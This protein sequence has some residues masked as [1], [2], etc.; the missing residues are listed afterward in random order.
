MAQINQI[1]EFNRNTLSSVGS[2][3]KKSDWNTPPTLFN[4]GL[5]E[6]VFHLID[7]KISND[8]TECDLL[9]YFMSYFQKLNT[10]VNYL[11]IGVSVGKTFYQICKF[12]QSH[13]FEGYKLHCL[14]IE[15]MNPT[16]KNLINSTLS[17]DDHL[18]TMIP[19]KPKPDSIRGNDTISL[20]KWAHRNSEIMYHES[21]E[22]ADDVWKTMTTPYNV[23]FSDALHEPAALLKEYKNLK[24]YN[25]I[26]SEGF[27]YCFD[28][29]EANEND[30]MWSA[31]KLIK[32][33]LAIK[34]PGILLEHL[35]VNGWL[36]QNEHPHHFGVI[37]WHPH[38]PCDFT[39]L[40]PSKNVS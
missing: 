40:C 12:I 7:A 29:L 9:C 1:I 24:K 2:W 27:I 13:N 34:Y 31:V 30:R 19:S 18:V 37:H 10:P 25:I 32:A 35:V 23:I 33:D 39:K 5:P 6:H 8:I 14:D 3:I 16:F 17:Y 38:T 28:D 11:E 36:G 26:A 22:F 20:S 15:I 4:Y 21:D